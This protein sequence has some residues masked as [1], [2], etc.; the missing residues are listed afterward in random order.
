MAR[1]WRDEGSVEC[2]IDSDAVAIYARIADVTTAGARSTEN[3]SC[4]WLPGPAPG[5]VGAR[6]RGRNRSG[7]ARWSRVCEVLEADPGRRF[8]FRTVPERFD[9]SRTDSTTWSYLLVPEGTGTRVTH[10]YRITKWP[11]RPIKSLYG[12]FF[13]QHRDMRPQ[14]THT[15]EALR[16]ELEGSNGE[17]APAR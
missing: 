15:L 10:A 4:E 14:M 3:R 6:F 16:A 5:T 12:R 2:V 11:S 7:L 9:P 17:E 8:S 13:P 1:A